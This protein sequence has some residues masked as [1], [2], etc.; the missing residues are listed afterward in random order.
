MIRK[1][2]KKRGH[3]RVSRDIDPDEIFMDSQNLPEFDRD[4][5]E[6]RIEKSVSRKSITFLVLMF[7]IIFVFLGYRIFSLQVV[8]GESFREISENNRLRHSIIFAVRGNIRDRNDN[9]LAWNE[10][11]GEED[12]FPKRVYAERE[13]F[14]N[15]IGYIKYPQKDDAGFFYEF[16]YKGIDGAEELFDDQLSGENGRTIVETNALG[17]VISENTIFNSEQGESVTLSIDAD[18]QE[19]LHESVKS[20]ADEVEFSGGG[21]IIMDIHTG[22]ILAMTTYPELDSQKLTDGDKEYLSNANSDSRNPFLNRITQGLYT[23]GSIV[24]PFVA[25]AVLNEDVIDPTTNI[26]SRGELEVPNPY[27]PSKPTFFSDWKAHGSVDLK[28]ALAVSSNI[29]FYVVGGGYDDIEGLGI[30]RLEKY[31]RDFGFGSAVH[32]DVNSSLAGTVPNPEWKAENFDGDIW[33]LGDTYFTSIGQYGFQTTPIQ[34]VRSVAMLANEGTIYKPKLLKDAEPEID[35]Q[36][37]N[38]DKENYRIVK[39]GM[40]QA[41]TDGTAKGLLLPN[42]EIAAKTG[43]A[44]LGVSKARVNSWVVGFFP[45]DNPKYAFT[46]VMEK[47]SRNNFIGGVAVMRRLFDWM[48]INKPEYFE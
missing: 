32:G 36:V 26:V 41:V 6:G 27:D 45:Y 43:T 15:L 40:R 4:Q 7:S 19:K 9:L 30:T 20:I 13:G 33:R 42:V 37:E 22:E 47:G 17:D 23:P 35:I 31:M 28:K 5:F 2:L 11:Q 24:K 48:T 8:S 44:E 21:G 1:I 29:Y 34:I 39:E 12:D 10:P 14:A 38:I 46:V 3:V 16:D 25:L 18:I